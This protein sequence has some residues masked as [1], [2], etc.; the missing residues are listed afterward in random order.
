M[1]PG[2]KKEFPVKLRIQSSYRRYEMHRQVHRTDVVPELAGRR[3]M[4]LVA[5]SKGEKIF[6]L[7]ASRQSHVV[8]TRSPRAVVREWSRQSPST[9][10]GASDEVLELWSESDRGSPRAQVEER[11]TKSPSCGRRVIEAV[12]EHEVVWPEVPEHGVVWRVPE[13]PKAQSGLAR[14]PRAR[15][16]LASPRAR[17]WSGRSP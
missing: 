8:E 10:Q 3:G 13:G 16:G 9:S 12:P 11:A 2:S 1:V 5:R 7:Y 17:G 6:Q 15:S 4:S 14:S